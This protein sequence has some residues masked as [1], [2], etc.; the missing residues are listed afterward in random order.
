MGS[1]VF[2]CGVCL[3]FLVKHIFHHPFED[4]IAFF[5]SFWVK[6]NGF[7]KHIYRE[8]GKIIGFESSFNVIVPFQMPL[9]EKMKMWNLQLDYDTNTMQ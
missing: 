7:Y 1:G 8:G 9:A 2:G 4:S 5:A 6:Q 3:Q